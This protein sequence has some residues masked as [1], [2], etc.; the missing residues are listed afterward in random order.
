MPPSATRAVPAMDAIY[1]MPGHLIRRAHQVSTALFAEECGKVGLTSVQFAALYAVRASG[2]LDATR[3]AEQI[4]F[5]R[6]TIGDVLDRLQAKGWI[7]RA[8]SR[9]D[10]RVKLIRLTAKGAALLKR[11]EPAVARVQERLL[12][13]LSPAEHAQFLALL[14]RV[15]QV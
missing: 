2:E 5:D 12:A 14:Y 13:P 10:R 8:G 3:L 9:D 15:G 6:A 11:V 1:A 7:A 4:A